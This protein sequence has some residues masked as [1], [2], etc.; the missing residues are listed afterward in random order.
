ML[1]SVRYVRIIPLEWSPN[2]IG[3]RV[4]LRTAEPGAA[5]TPSPTRSPTYDI[6]PEGM[7]RTVES[8]TMCKP[9]P[10]G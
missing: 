10:R 1:V 8:A 4:D 5:A 7:F 6:C 9:C 3:L 2:G